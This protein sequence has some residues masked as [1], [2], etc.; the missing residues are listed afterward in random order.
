MMIRNPNTAATGMARVLDRVGFPHVSECG[1]GRP[2]SAWGSRPRSVRS[3]G[4]RDTSGSPASV[5][6][7]AIA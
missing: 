2:D 6:G 1:S 7:D 5:A 4:Q 3:H